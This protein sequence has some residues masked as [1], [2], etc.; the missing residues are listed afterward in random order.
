MSID[1]INYLLS[2]YYDSLTSMQLLYQNELENPSS[3]PD[4]SVEP[5]IRYKVEIDLMKKLIE[6]LEKLKDNLESFNI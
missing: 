4:D 2:K 6:Q 5:K 1:T 3:Y